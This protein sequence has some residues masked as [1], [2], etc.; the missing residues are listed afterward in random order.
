MYTVT[1]PDPYPREGV[2]YLTLTSVPDEYNSMLTS[3]TRGE[4]LTPNV[5]VN[6]RPD[7]SPG[8][9]LGNFFER[10][11]SSPPGT[12]VKS[13][14]LGQKNHAKIPLPGQLFSNIQQKNPQNM[15]QIL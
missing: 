9:L 10:V 12:S 7:H 4:M 11:N 3:V 1:R 6:S 8:K 5:S 14:P 13:Q 15:K 2:N